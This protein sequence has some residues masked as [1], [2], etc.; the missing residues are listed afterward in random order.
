VRYRTM[1][2]SA[3]AE[4][5]DDQLTPIPSK[6]IGEAVA[7]V[8]FDGAVWSGTKVESSAAAPG[9]L[10]LPELSLVNELNQYDCFSLS[11]VT[12]SLVVDMS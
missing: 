4:T 8:T 7:D 1:T 11:P 6:P 12:L 5:D 3:S 9:E 10:Q 2:D